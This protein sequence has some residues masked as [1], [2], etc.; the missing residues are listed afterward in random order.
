LSATFGLEKKEKER[1][2]K[3]HIQVHLKTPRAAQLAMI[4]RGGCDDGVSVG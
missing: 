4:E 3:K 2:K 1:E